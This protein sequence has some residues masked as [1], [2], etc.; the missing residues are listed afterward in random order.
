MKRI[1]HLIKAGIPFQFDGECIS[2]QYPTIQ[3][4]VVAAQSVYGDTIDPSVLAVYLGQTRD[5]INI[6]A[7]LLP[8]TDTFFW[9]TLQGCFSYCFC[10]F[11]LRSDRDRILDILQGQFLFDNVWFE[12]RSNGNTYAYRK[13]W[14]GCP[15]LKVTM[16]PITE[17]EYEIY[18]NAEA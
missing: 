4:A 12:K 14:E 5:E 3:A 10:G 15:P 1:A 13:A 6:I 8:L 16:V 7:S 11:A 9:Y 17:T 2:V 18:I